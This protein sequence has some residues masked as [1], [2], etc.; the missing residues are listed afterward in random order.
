M[1]ELFFDIETKSVLDVRDCGAHRYARD[2]ST[3]PWC[4]AFA[5]DN[6]PVELWTPE[7]PVP[8]AFLDAARD[9]SWITIA[10]ND[11][12]E[13][14]I[15]RH[16]LV[17]RYQF[18]EIPVKR[19][20][21]SMAL[22]LAHALP[23][24][25][26][27]LGEVVAL[28]HRK[29]D[30]TA[31]RR[32]ARPRKPKKDED[33][34]AGPFWHDDAESI[35][36]LHR[37]CI[38][39]VE[40]MRELFRRL[41]PLS[42]DEQALWQLDAAVNDR[43]FFVDAP[44]LEAAVK[45]AAAADAEIVAELT[46]ITAGEIDSPGQT[47]RIVRW[48]AAR[49]CIV[50]DAQRETLRRAAARKGL[51]P[52]VRRV[53]EL[54]MRGAHAAARKLEAMA[55]WRCDDNRV[56]GT[57]TFHGASTGR[58][59]GRGPQP[60]N[61]KRP[62]T[63]DL[64]AAIDAVSS[65]DIARVKAAY[66]GPLEAVANITRAIPCAPPGKRLMIA[67]FS[68]VES[69]VAA[70]LAGERSKLELWRAFD[71]SGGDPALD[72]YAILGGRLGLPPDRARDGGKIADLAFSFGGS[73]GAW[74]NVSPDD[75]SSEAEIK[76]KQQAWRAQHPEICQYWR[77]LNNAAVRA[78][79][80][81]GQVSRCNKIA[82]MRDGDFLYAIL[83][84]GRRIAYPFPSLIAGKYGD[85]VSCMDAS[86]G[87]WGPIRFGAGL[88]GG[89]LL[90]NCTQ[91]CARDLL[92]AALMRL[93]ATGLYLPALHVHDEVVCEVPENFG[94][95]EEFERLVVA[96]P[97]WAVGLPVSAKVRSGTR[98]CKVEAPSSASAKPRPETAAPEPEPE[99]PPEP[100][101]ERD[102][103][104]EPEPRRDRNYEKSNGRGRGRKEAEFVYKLASGAPYLLVEKW[105]SETDHG[106]KWFWQFHWEN[107]ARVRG[108]PSPRIPY[109]LPELI[110][111]P[112][113]EPVWIA[114][115]E[116]DADAVAALGLVSTTNPEGAGKWRDELCPWFKGKRTVYLLEDNDAAG[117]AH[118][119]KVADSL[120]RVVSEIRV[121]EFPELAE[122]G[123]VSDW[124]AAGHGKAELITRAQAAKD[125][126]EPRLA[127]LNIGDWDRIAVPRQEWSVPDRFPLRQTVL[128]SGEGGEGKSLLTLHLCAAHALG[129]EWLDVIPEQGP[130][131]FL[132]A[133]DDA[134]VLHYRLDAIRHHYG[135]TFDALA[136]G[137]LHLISRV[138]DDA[139][140]AAPS[141][142]SGII[143]PTARYAEL[144]EMAGDIRPK[145]IAVAS[146][147]DV[148]AGNE[149]D[150]SAVRQ[151]IG[152]LTKLAIIA[153]GSVL[154]I[155]HPSLTGIATGS[156]LSGST[157]WHNSVRA[158]AV[159]KS[160]KAS[161]DDGDAEGNGEPVGS[162]LR[163][164]A[165]RKSNY[166]PI[167]ASV[168]VRYRGGLFLPEATSSVDGAARAQKAEEIFLAL[169]GRFTAQ[170]QDVCPIQG[171]TY[172]PTLF[173]RHPDA[174]GLKFDDLRDA[175]QRLLDAGRLK[176]EPFGP[177]SKP[178]KR[179]VRV[180]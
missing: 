78:V 63:D 64:G 167:A 14:A 51:A 148:F 179:L 123:D 139:V 161:D 1:P 127:F 150:R 137:G 18:L 5:V 176:I 6:G 136:K 52:D 120:R 146:S 93:E 157:Q 10:H 74:K 71:R 89:F 168:F 29:A 84:S 95:L 42:A 169:L 130:A 61:M 112:P 152:L 31:M 131:I 138:G 56:R 109:R 82:F 103:E 30:N 119:A 60:Q 34:A 3:A 165:F 135:T 85:V 92:A 128:F 180:D 23:P 54:R 124:L 39:D 106:E 41:P 76:A 25:L 156:G 155:A 166:G 38:A 26:A 140:L 110:A 81:P 129:R 118:V 121:V 62:E 4:I 141:L 164:I 27:K 87:R 104:P 158:R 79:S 115:G 48:L 102:D 122:H 98:F 134:R 22:A 49:D 65:G 162:T 99:A 67:D 50:T 178:R 151:F 2:A 8:L 91:G 147:A 45:V 108:A 107:G 70:F 28:E 9:E 44:L 175:M 114:E 13:R 43:G 33:P 142:R 105:R 19:R 96:L 35:A 177:P 100:E 55:A 173:A 113:V 88:Y 80:A 143:E 15:E 101:P 126:A 174:A 125:R 160:V 11:Q 12:F 153:S 75:T 170:G 7:M 66:S 90:E 17:P 32:M 68:G 132:D 40:A 58:W 133:E 144:L 47:D 21:C 72:P 57:L 53:I 171:K 111:A 69:R 24:S 94:S 159:I 37:Y 77:V 46:A 73:I 97:E 163:Q 59:A 172:A 145:L 154:L 149:V 16:I 20:H 116:K 117:R 86:G 36:T 83:P